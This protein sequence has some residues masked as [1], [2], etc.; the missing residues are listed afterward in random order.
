MKSGQKGF[1]VIETLLVLILI[2]IIGFTGYY[3]WHTQKNTNSSYNN[4]AKSNSS[5]PASAET[6]NKFVFKELGVEFTLTDNLKGLSYA[7]FNGSDYISDSAFKE[8]LNE[9]TDVN[10]TA[11]GDALA[12]SYTAI[13]K[14]KGQYPANANPID[15]GAL[16]KQF[17]DFYISYGVP[18]GNGC[19]D[20]SQSE[21]L[22]SVADTERSYFIDAFKATATEVK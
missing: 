10:Q 3:V 9:C 1:T 5:T 18:N 11:A 2:S 19:S 14:A 8:A 4:A 15:Y 16:L 22:K 12:A 20:L 13:S 7:T 6:S 21:N 17:P